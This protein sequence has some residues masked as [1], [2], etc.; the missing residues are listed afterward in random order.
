MNK[1]VFSFI[2]IVT[3][4]LG[5]VLTGGKRVKADG[6]DNDYVI[7]EAS[8]LNQVDYCYAT[9]QFEQSYYRPQIERINEL[10][11][12]KGL[13]ELVWDY[14]LEAFA[15]ERCAEYAMGAEPH[16]NTMGNSTGYYEVTASGPYDMVRTVSIFSQS[17]AH[18]DIL[19]N[20]SLKCLGIAGG[21]I[22]E[23]AHGNSS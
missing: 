15:M 10:R 7:Y 22:D 13:D 1:K 5:V 18:M 19:M 20:P 8:Y 12:S 3:L 4:A 14:N 16:K 23:H 21:R 9:V 17:S 6:L 11:R 2:L